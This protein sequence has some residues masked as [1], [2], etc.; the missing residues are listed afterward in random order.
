MAKTIGIN[1]FL[2]RN[3]DTFDFEGDWL[4]HLGKPEK[5]FRAIVYGDS[6]N[7]KTDYV[8]KKCKYLA[9]LGARSYYN[10]F[11]EGISCTLQEAV[12][13]NNLQEVSGMIH[14]AN[15]ESFDE[16]CARISKPRSAHHL[17]IDS[18]DYMNMTTA[19]YKKLDS[20][21]KRKAITIICW[22]SGKK[23]KGQYARD[24]EY[25]CDIKT[26]VR[27][28]KAHTRCRFGGNQPYT[29]WDKKPKEGEQLQIGSHA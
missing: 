25:M 10:S 16:M 3:F 8:I 19:Q 7:G 24:I 2:A 12:R 13:R 6:G 27:N 29:I 18:R 4:A 17:V 28:F 11:E 14:F 21:F 15:K 23:P 1:Q 20:M 9:T 22:M 5:N 26:M